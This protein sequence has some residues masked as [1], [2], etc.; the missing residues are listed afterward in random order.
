MRR[1]VVIIRNM[2]AKFAPTFSPLYSV[3]LKFLQENGPC[4]HK[5]FLCCKV[6]IQKVQSV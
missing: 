6:V 4:P 1:N 2:N 5:A 3:D